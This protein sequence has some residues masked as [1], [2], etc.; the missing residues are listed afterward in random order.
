[1]LGNGFYNEIDRLGVW[2]FDN[3]A[4]HGRPRLLCELRLTYTDGRVETVASDESWQAAESPFL[5]NDIYSGDTYDARREL[6]GMEQPDFDTSDWKACV[7]A[8]A[9][10]NLLV[11]QQMPATEVDTIYRPV[12]LRS[13][14][15]SIYVIDFGQNMSGYARLTLQ[16]QAGTQIRIQHGEELDAE[17]RLNVDRI[18][19]L[20]DKGKGFGFQTD[21]YT[22]SGR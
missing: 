4:W 5:V 20:F 10:S 15:D 11:A 8:E 22:L 7:Q 6:E 16:G 2:D 3:A 17:G 12:S 18:T 1:M 13:I 21:V 19:G 9:P 14:G